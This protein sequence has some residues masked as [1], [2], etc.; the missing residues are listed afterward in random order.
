M[1]KP[2][3]FSVDAAQA[4]EGTLELVV[5]TQHTT[6]KAEV[7][8][9]ARGLYDVTFVPLTAEDHF[10]NITFNDISVVGSPFHCS[11]VSNNWWG[12]YSFASIIFTL[13]IEATQY[14]QIGS[15]C[16]MD[17]PSDNHRLEI[18]DPN[19]HNVKYVVKDYKAQFVLTQTGT[20]R[21]HSYKG[22]E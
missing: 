6:I 18:K 20:Y 10:V 17:L 11:V 5:S 14:L 15:S 3:T 22:H 4:G 8:A 2:V 16:Y 21:V 9:C 12:E 7:V 1:G 19:N 13:K